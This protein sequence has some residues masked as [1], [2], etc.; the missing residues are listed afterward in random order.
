VD[1]T[2][3]Y[4]KIEGAEYSFPAWFPGGAKSLIRRILE[5]NLD[6]RIRIE[7]IR[8]DEW[9][10]KNYEPVK[11]VENEEV[12]LDD[13]NGAFDNPEAAVVRS[14]RRRSKPRRCLVIHKHQVSQILTSFVPKQRQTLM[15]NPCIGFTL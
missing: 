4:G 8:N 6:T 10:K 14:N 15:H 7:E 9:F 13:V 3:L 2:A 12:N 11:E 1:R 5:P